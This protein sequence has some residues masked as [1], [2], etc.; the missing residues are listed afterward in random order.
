MKTDFF[1]L[2]PVQAVKVTPQN[3][4]EVAA[5]CGGV[6][7][8]TDSRRV[9]G[10][11]D[12]Y[13]WVPTPKGSAISWAFPGMFVTR[14][15]VWTVDGKF[16]ETW[17]VFRREYFDKNYFNTPTNAV[18][19]TWEKFLKPQGKK[20]PRKVEINIFQDG[21]IA[22]SLSNAAQTIV[23]SFAS[24]KAELDLAQRVIE[25]IIPGSTVLGTEFRHNHP[26]GNRCGEHECDI[27]RYADGYH[28]FTDRSFMTKGE[29]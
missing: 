14:R 6:V 19:A 21:Q 4:E 22:S 18:D 13:V 12:K 7:A 23:G 24:S 17:A 16:K 11:K 29:N 1:F 3:L 25:E 28:I 26:F 27:E 15:V 9:P 5:W 10:R 20:E 8:E 2:S